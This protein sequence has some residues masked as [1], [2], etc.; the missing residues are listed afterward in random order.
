M[1]P[2]R[3]SIVVVTVL[4]SSCASG[5]KNTVGA[6]YDADSRYCQELMQKANQPTRI[7]N[8]TPASPNQP[9]PSDR[10]LYEQMCEPVSAWQVREAK[11]HNRL[12]GVE[13]SWLRRILKV[14]F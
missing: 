8:N 4:I 10:Q 11:K 14:L 9:A 2:V 6:A 12:G 7:P 3:Y 5:P 13:K 1:I